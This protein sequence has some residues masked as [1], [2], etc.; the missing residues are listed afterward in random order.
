MSKEDPYIGLVI[1][2]YR[3]DGLLGKG[4]MGAVYKGWDMDLQR[5]VAIKILSTD[6]IEDEDA[7]TRFDREARILAELNHPNICQVFRIGKYG[8]IPFYAMEHLDGRS[9]KDVL[10]QVRRINVDRAIRI[11]LQIA[12]G[13][14][15]AHEKGITHRDIK[16]ANIMLMRDDMVK[17]VDFGIAKAFLDDTFKTATGMLLG[18]PR[19]MSPEQGRGANVD[20]RSDIYSLGCTFYHILTGAPPFSAQNAIQLIEKHM[21]EPVRS[22]TERNPNVPD[23]LCNLIYGMLEKNP[24]DRI[25]DY[26]YLVI[27]LQNIQDNQANQTYKVHAQA[28]ARPVDAED[29]KKSRK[30]VLGL[31]VSVV[32]VLALGVWMKQQR[33]DEEAGK[34]APG[35]YEVNSDTK[36]P[37]AIRSALRTLHEYREATEK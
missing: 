8:D 32:F 11:V 7:V 5:Q 17:I 28:P 24:A 12:Q 29:Q 23:K 30:M 1:D 26:S 27:S 16:P 14:K 19:Y 22:I 20:F 33:P 4:G 37:D 25:S 15:A 21:K 31:V 35:A 6:L 34:E 3:I 2:G 9:L 36:R 13:L 10:G 18:T